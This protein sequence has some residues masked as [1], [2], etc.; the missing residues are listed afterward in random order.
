MSSLS[1]RAGLVLMADGDFVDAGVV[2]TN[3]AKL[4]TI[5]SITQCLSSSRPATP[6]DGQ[7]IYETDTKNIRRWNSASNVWYLL[8][9]NGSNSSSG[10][11]GTASNTSAATLTIP[12][13]SSGHSQIS[14]HDYNFSLT[15]NKIYKI[16][17][18]GWIWLTGSF[19]NTGYKY[20]VG[21]WTNLGI[22]SN[23]GLGSSSAVH[24][25]YTFISDPQ[26]QQRIP[27]YKLFYV[28]TPGGSGSTTHYFR[29]VMDVNLADF[30]PASRTLGRSADATSPSTVHVYDMGATTGN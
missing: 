16:I 10:Y 12:S 5:T 25:R 27:Y 21:L 6:F 9:G 20:N 2:T 19:N 22:G 3:A 24:V 26:F 28:Q 1:P 29:S 4:D 17:E 8:G 23:P 18:Q 11:F 30:P 13:G 7:W 15:N 14:L